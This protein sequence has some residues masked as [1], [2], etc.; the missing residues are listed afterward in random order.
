MNTNEFFL[1]LYVFV[2]YIFN[3]ILLIIVGA[4]EIKVLGIIK[5]YGISSS[6]HSCGNTGFESTLRF[7]C[8]HS[9]YQQINC[10]SVVLFPGW[11]S[12]WFHRHAEQKKLQ[13]I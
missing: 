7:V 5:Y 8:S 3:S 6:V 9:G 10:F 13:F 11:F 4:L 2:L 12:N 1:G